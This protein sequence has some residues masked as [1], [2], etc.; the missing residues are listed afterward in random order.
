MVWWGPRT[1]VDSVRYGTKKR[2][3]SRRSAETR[4][5]GGP[6][7]LRQFSQMFLGSTP[8]PLTLKNC[9]DYSLT[10]LKNRFIVRFCGGK[11]R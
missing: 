6:R 10:T 8:V 5:A 3:F 7:Y 11:S 4:A 1:R 2:H 9:T